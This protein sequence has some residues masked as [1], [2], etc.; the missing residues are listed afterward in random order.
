M[1]ESARTTTYLEH[2]EIRFAC[3]SVGEGRPLVLLHGL[4]GNRAGALELADPA[5]GW[6]RVAIDQRGHGETEPVGPDSG[7]NFETMAADLHALLPRLDVNHAVIAGVSMGA[8]VALRF[9][10]DHPD[11]V[12]ALILVR[13]AWIE[14]PATE[15]LEPYVAISG[16][17]RTIPVAE[18]LAAL[19]ASETYR[20]VRSV[21]PHAGETLRSEVTSPRAVECAVRLDRMPR[22]VPFADRAEL[23]AVTCPT[24]VVGCDRDPLHPLEYAQI[25]AGLIPDAKFQLVASSADDVPQH[26]RD[27]RWAIADH[28]ARLDQAPH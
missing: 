24:L 11:L 17:L 4:G 1:I 12:N 8:S 18:A 7:Y 2:D 20:R 27:V 28:L 15:N 6:R 21:S 13:P 3:E 23:R 19:E 16:L 22:S 5:P 14:T 10:L 26:R 9:A 25:W